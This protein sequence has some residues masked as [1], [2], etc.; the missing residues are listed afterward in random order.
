MA[1]DHQVIGKIGRLIS[2][3]EPGGMGEVMLP[4]RGGTE[5][6]YAYAAEG[7]EEIPKGTR[8]IV[9][10]HDPPRTVIVSRYP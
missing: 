7:S 4:V 1:A 10:E 8:V 5:A 6:F 9:L 2:A 3:I